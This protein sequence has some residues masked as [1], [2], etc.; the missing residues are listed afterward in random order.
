MSTVPI[1][2]FGDILAV[3][4]PLNI[5]TLA[6]GAVRWWSSSLV[7]HVANCLGGETCIDARPKNGVSEHSVHVFDK[8]LWVLLRPN[9][10]FNAEQIRKGTEFLL[11]QKGKKYDF[12][13][14][15]GFPLGDP[16]LEKQNRWICSELTRVW[17][18]KMD[19]YPTVRTPPGFTSP[20][21]IFCSPIL[22]IKAT[23]IEDPELL[24][25]MGI[26]TI[27]LFKFVLN[28]KITTVAA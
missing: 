19:F 10:R 18:E 6:Q 27:N 22:N 12:M 9:I 21:T 3:R 24:N 7:D 2:K 16:Y 11:Q 20:Q 5:H 25:L 26:D 13:G 8:D 14:I 23:N 4:S 28:H 17:C 1:T 15:L